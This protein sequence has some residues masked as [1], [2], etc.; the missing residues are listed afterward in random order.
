MMTEIC[1]LVPNGSCELIVWLMS[2]IKQLISVILA[3]IVPV[4]QQIVI[5]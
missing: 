4:V 2:K 3:A 5:R 1:A